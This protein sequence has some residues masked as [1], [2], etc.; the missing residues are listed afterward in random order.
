MRRLFAIAAAALFI[1]SLAGCGTDQPTGHTV[2]KPKELVDPE[3]S[4]SGVP[5]SIEAGGTF[6]VSVASNSPGDIS[7]KTDKTTV[8]VATAAGDRKWDITVGS[9]SQDTKVKITA[10]QDESKAE[11]FASISVSATFTVLGSGDS[12]DDDL[13]GP[14]DQVDGTKVSFTE[15][16]GEMVSPERGMYSAYEVHK[17]TSALTTSAV[18]S[19]L[20]SGNS[21]WLIE[22]YLTDF[23][24]GN[25]SQ[26]YLD[27]I[28]SCF[29]GIRGGGAKAIVRFAY[30][31]DHNQPELDQEPTLEVV[32]KHIAQVKPILQRNEDVLFCL[33]A[34]FIGTW[35]EWYY[36]T[37][38]GL[39]SN[40]TQ[41][42]MQ[43]R[44][45][46]CDALLDAVP[47]SRQVQLRTPA[48]KMKMYSLALKDTIT[49]A[50]AHGETASARLG[51]H[52]D[53]F[54][55]DESDEGTFES[56]DGR[57]FWKADTRYTIMGGETCKVSDYCLCPNTLQDLEDYH[58]TYL[59]DGYNEQVLSRWKK[60]GCM[61]EI[62]ARLGYRLVLKDL[63]HGSVEKG[64]ECK[65]IVRMYN[66]GFAAP[67]N[68]RQ[69]W[70]VWVGSDGKT[71]KSM[72]GVDPRSWQPGYNAFA[73]KFTPSTDKGTLYLELPDPML[74]D[75]PAYSMALANEGVFDVKTGYNKLFE[76]K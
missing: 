24:T 52:N 46:V 69:A 65:V 1:G 23:M 31:V 21:L 73:G 53:C 11:G 54:G 29:D 38:F 5:T 57:N 34:G 39:G 6:T 22:F 28:Q 18:K 37:H 14:D 64:K 45:E 66:N 32:L 43:Q 8:A 27:K 48:F 19:K 70:L 36:S 76:I 71:V 47:A 62:R 58:W 51:G 50:T 63:H 33:Q 75:N 40:I 74:A 35:G 30:R 61:P 72:L 25:I 67:M 42:Q 9:V 3:I 49:M 16:D 41:A 17:N 13:P 68:P 44:K 26:T 7:L 12:G 59:H 20:Q 56:T 10:T 2:T 4:I 55:A 60:D 15:L